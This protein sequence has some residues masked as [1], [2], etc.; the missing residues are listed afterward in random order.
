MWQGAIW[1]RLPPEASVPLP[2]RVG[3]PCMRTVL[4]ARSAAF[5]Q[6]F[7][8]SRKR[9]PS[10][11]STPCWAAC[12]LPLPGGLTA[13]ADCARCC[14]GGGIGPTGRLQPLAAR[15]LGGDVELAQ[16]CCHPAR[17]RARLSVIGQKSRARGLV[18][19]CVPN[20]RGN[21]KT[22]NNPMH[23]RSRRGFAACPTR[24][25]TA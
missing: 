21:K 14:A 6:V 20:S 5:V 13:A 15:P 23:S 1:R 2:V 12:S 17:P 3:W 25:P 4:Q 16:T 22:G 19:P 18:T 24:G 9:R 7:W 10:R 8:R 11:W